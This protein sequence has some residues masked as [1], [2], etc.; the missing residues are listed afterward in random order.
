MLTKQCYS[1]ELKLKVFKNYKVYI[2]LLSKILSSKYIKKLLKITVNNH[3]FWFFLDIYN[4]HD[5]NYK[6]LL[7][8]LQQSLRKLSLE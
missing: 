1:L 8:K 6:R 7:T 3:L 2:A 4:F 5:K